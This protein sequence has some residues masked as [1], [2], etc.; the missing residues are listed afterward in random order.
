MEIENITFVSR[1]LD[2][3][4]IPKNIAI[5]CK[6]VSNLTDVLDFIKEIPKITLPFSSKAVKKMCDYLYW[7]DAFEKKENP[8]E[9][10]IEPDILIE[11]SLLADYCLMD[12]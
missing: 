7:R 3:Y 4:N 10:L 1:D 11:L 12:E 5:Y 2:E 8:G 6:I 9:F